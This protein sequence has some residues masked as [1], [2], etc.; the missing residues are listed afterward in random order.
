M[1]PV[2][3]SKNF[4]D[5]YSASDRVPLSTLNGNW[6]NPL[7]KEEGVSPDRFMT[8]AEGLQGEDEAL[9]QNPFKFDCAFGYTGRFEPPPTPPSTRVGFLTA[10]KTEITKIGV[11]QSGMQAYQREINSRK[12]HIFSTR[13]LV[14][15]NTAIIVTLAQ[16]DQIIQYIKR[17]QEEV[18]AIQDEDAVIENK[19]VMEFQ[20]AQSWVARTRAILVHSHVFYKIN[21]VLPGQ[22]L[23]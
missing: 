17:A 1:T 22:K 9:K 16:L 3:L 20:Q 7:G 6:K 18:E 15:Q 2:Y 10:M 19:L 8:G 12:H 21:F 14:D 23:H 4:P 13:F 11:L 5:N